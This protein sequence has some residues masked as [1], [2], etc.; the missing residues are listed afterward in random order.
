MKAWNSGEPFGEDA[1]S[2]LVGFA[3]PGDAHPGSFEAKVD[4]A[5]AREE[6]SD[7]HAVFLLCCQNPEQGQ[8]SRSPVGRI[9]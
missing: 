8:S 9:V 5:D 7:I 4:T 3:L 6:A 2:P 1:A